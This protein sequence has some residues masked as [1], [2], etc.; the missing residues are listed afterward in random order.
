MLE[1]DVAIGDYF[2]DQGINWQTFGIQRETRES[3]IR[4]MER[5][6]EIH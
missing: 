4:L 1:K 3:M 6:I 5:L 2:S